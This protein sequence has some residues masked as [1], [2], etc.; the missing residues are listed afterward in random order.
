MVLLHEAFERQVADRP[1]APALTAGSLNLSYAQ[2]N[3]R[4]NRLAHALIEYGVTA[5]MPVGLCLDM[6]PEHAPDLIAGILAILK[7][8]GGY[9]P[10]DPSLPAGRLASIVDQA[11]PAVVLTSENLLDRFENSAGKLLS[12]Q[13]S[14]RMLCVDRDAVLIAAQPEKDPRLPV[15]RDHLC[16]VMF[17]SGSTGHP[18]G[19]MVT[20]GNVAG[21]FDGIGESLGLGPDDVWTLFHTFAFGFSVWEIWGALKHGGRLVLLPPEDRADPVRVFQIIREQ[22]VTVLSQTPS[23]FRQVLSSPGFSEMTDELDLR[24]VVLSGEPAQSQ[25]LAA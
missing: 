14:R 3:A 1:A 18:K 15:E 6:S 7:A 20:H 22:R 13:P 11:A 25:D 23:A 9:V 4:A 12:G 24:L 21:L 8:G 16:Y 10:L 19:V 5:D 2:L 17:T